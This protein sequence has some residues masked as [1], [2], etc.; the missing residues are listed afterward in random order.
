MEA[1]ETTKKDQKNIKKKNT[2]VKSILEN[3]A[4]FISH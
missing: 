2:M 4:H 3:S 1:S